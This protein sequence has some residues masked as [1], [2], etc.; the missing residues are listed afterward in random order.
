MTFMSKPTGRPH[1]AGLEC[2]LRPEYWRSLFRDRDSGE[3]RVKIVAAK[4]LDAVSDERMVAI[5][6]LTNNGD[7]NTGR[8][9]ADEKELRRA[10][11]TV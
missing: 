5:K 1:A 11:Q 7:R 8:S 6:N 10:S 2:P 4:N 9:I 3:E